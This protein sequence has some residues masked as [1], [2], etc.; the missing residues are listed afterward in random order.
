[1]RVR[2]IVC[3]TVELPVKAVLSDELAEEHTLT[4]SL[5]DIQPQSIT[6]GVA[7][8]CTFSCVT[9]VIDELTTDEKEYS[10]V[11]E[12]GMCFLPDKNTVKIKAVFDVDEKDI[13][14]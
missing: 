7:P 11:Q 12:E 6:V 9:A 8:G 13:F 10:L 14:E 2:N 4:E 1:M 5:T 3:N